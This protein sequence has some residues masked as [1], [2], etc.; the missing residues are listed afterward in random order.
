MVPQE[1]L[2][3]AGLGS[4]KLSLALH[5]VGT[6]HDL[7]AS[8]SCDDVAFLEGAVGMDREDLPRFRQLVLAARDALGVQPAPT[9]QVRSLDS[10]MV[11]AHVGGSA[12]GKLPLALGRAE[13]CP[14][15]GS[16]GIAFSLDDVCFERDRRPFPKHAESR[17]RRVITLDLRQPLGVVLGQNL[18]VQRIDAKGQFNGQA[19]KSGHRFTAV[20]DEPVASL[21][22]FYSMV[23]YHMER[24]SPT[25]EL[26]FVVADA[27]AEF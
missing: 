22:D 3:N 7:A 16:G 4:Y 20:A 27:F 21:D 12:A 6:V 2:Q 1:W 19:L 15:N 10:M 13:T 11:E 23:E 5:G 26:T 8:P 14:A 24:G 25:C 18:S 17:D 9:L